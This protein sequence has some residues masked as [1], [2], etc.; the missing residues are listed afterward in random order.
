MRHGKYPFIIG[1]LVVPVALYAIFV[2]GPYIQAFQHL[3]DQLARRLDQAAASSAWTTSSKLWDDDAVLK[4]VRHNAVLLVFLPLVTIV[5]AL[6]FAFLLNVGGGHE[7]RQMTRGSGARRSTGWSSS[8]RRCWPSPSSAVLFSRSTGP[9]EQRHDQRSARRRS[10]VE[11]GRLLIDRT[12]PLL[13]ASSVVLVWQAVGFYV[14][15][16]SAGMA[17]HPEGDLRGGRAGR[18]RP[19]SRCSSGSPCRCSGTPSRSPGSTSASPPS[20]RSRSC[21]VMTVDRG[22]PDGATT[23]LAPGDL[24]QR[25]QQYSQ[26]GYASA[27]GV[28]LFF[29]TL[30]FA[31]LTL[32]RHPAR[33]RSSSE[34]PRHD[35]NH[36]PRRP[37]RRSGQQ[38]P[39]RYRKGER[40][41][42]AQ[43]SAA[44]PTSR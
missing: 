27:L 25:L 24:P 6:F 17:L 16:F 44:S 13:V 40:H 26:S 19:V 37:G 22:G 11:P 34:R 18:R 43:C 1:F 36:R 42:R 39:A 21:Q 8:S 10:G 3:A 33:T 29:L 23:V 35:D 4:A 12:S 32:R 15:L 14:V 2:V 31:A 5:I 7:G 28:V 38:A 9:D 30:A 41:A 20:T